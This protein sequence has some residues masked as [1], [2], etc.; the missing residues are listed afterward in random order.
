VVQG[1]HKTA[2]REGR[3]NPRQGAS[4]EKSLPIGKRQHPG[5]RPGTVE[6]QQIWVYNGQATFR[7]VGSRN[8][9]RE[10]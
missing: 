10:L 1:L 9:L 3:L 7:G 4:H 6:S 5:G 8:C 2:R